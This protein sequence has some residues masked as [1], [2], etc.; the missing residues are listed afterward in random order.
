[1]GRGQIAAS[2]N[3]ITMKQGSGHAEETVEVKDDKPVTWNVN[4]P[5]GKITINIPEEKGFYVL[6]LK[7]DTIVGSQQNLGQ[8]L[9]GR[10]MTQEELKVKIDSLTKLTSGSNVSPGAH[11][12]FIPPNQLQ[13][14]TSDPDAKLYGPFN[15]I[16]RTIEADKD[17]KAPEMYKFYTNSGMR[18]LIARLKK[19]TI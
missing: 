6:N 13:K 4:T 14:I 11:N 8:D 16:P 5:S 18:E 17:G 19:N 10:T 9:S 7:S 15:N 1:M 12:Y 3:E 2:G